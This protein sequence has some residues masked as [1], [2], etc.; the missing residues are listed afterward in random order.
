MQSCT[1]PTAALGTEVCLHVLVYHYRIESFEISQ[2]YAAFT[3]T[4]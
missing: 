3:D 4:L 2:F 1:G